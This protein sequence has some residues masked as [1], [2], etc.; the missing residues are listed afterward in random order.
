[1]AYLE[2]NAGGKTSTITSNETKAAA[3]LTDV[4]ALFGITGGAQA[5]LDAVAQLI[6]T[7]VMDWSKQY[8]EQQAILAAKDDVADDTDNI[9]ED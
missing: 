5:Q 2:I 3:I 9:W 6:K 8:R 7:Q 1:M 4:A